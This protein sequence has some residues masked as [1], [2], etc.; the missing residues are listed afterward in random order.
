MA[1]RQT[2]LCKKFPKLRGPSK[3]SVNFIIEYTK[4]MSNQTIYHL[5]IM[6]SLNNNQSIDLLCK[7]TEWL[8]YNKNINLNYLIL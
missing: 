6:F 7:S 8:L 2:V 1:F 4:W 3:S 5:R